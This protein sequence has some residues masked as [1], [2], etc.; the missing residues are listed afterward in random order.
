[1][2]VNFLNLSGS[3]L[4]SSRSDDNVDEIMQNKPNK[5]GFIVQTNSIISKVNKVP[6]DQLQEPSFMVCMVVII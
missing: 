2:L 1:M 3:E 6:D 4:D 5:N